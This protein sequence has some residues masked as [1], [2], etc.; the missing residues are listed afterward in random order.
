MLTSV[1]DDNPSSTTA[2]NDFVPFPQSPRIVCSIVKRHFLNLDDAQREKELVG[3]GNNNQN[4]WLW[5]MKL[6]GRCVEQFPSQLKN[7]SV[8]TDG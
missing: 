6:L 4:C 7:T 8:V 2:A 5:C 3:D 1:P